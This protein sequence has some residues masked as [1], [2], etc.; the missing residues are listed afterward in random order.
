[1]NKFFIDNR[2]NFLFF[3]VSLIFLFAIIG[4][5]NIFF[6][7]TE[8]LYLGE[9]AMHQL[10]WHFFKNDIWRFPLGSNPN[11]GD[12]LGSSIVFSDSIPILALFFKLFKFFIPNNFQYFSFWY[13]I[14][15]YFQLFFAYKILQKF[16]NS[17]P[18]SFVGAIFFVIAPI[19]IYRIHLHS[20]LAGQWLLLFT[21]YLGLVH[22]VNKS[23]FLWSILLI[24]SS[25]IHFY[26]TA[27]ILVAYTILR[28]LNFYFDKEKFLQ[29]VKDF[30]IIILS[31]LLVL[32]L[33]GYFQIRM[34]DSLGVGFG[35]YKLNLLSIFDSTNSV[36]NISWSWILPDIKL[37]RGEEL[38]GFNYLGL[39]QILMLL[40]G[41]II[42]FGRNSSSINLFIRE[43]R[44]F[45]IFLFI[46][47]VFTCWAISSNISLG[48]H[49]YSIPLNKYI[50]GLLSIIKSSGRAFWLVNY[51]LLLL[52]IIIIF[53]YFDKKKSFL[54]ILIFLFI[55]IFD[56]SA[57]LKNYFKPFMPLY[58]NPMLAMDDRD[59]LKDEIWEDLFSNNKVIKTTYPVSWS[60]LFVKFA[61]LIE[62]YNMEKTNLVIFARSNRQANAQARYNL[63]NNLRSKQIKTNTVYIIHDL[64]HLRNLKSIFKDENVS[65]FYRDNMWSMALNHNDLINENDKENFN[66]IKPKLIEFNKVE[67]LI[68]ENKDNYYGFGWSHNLGKPGIWSEGKVS[69]LLFSVEESN[70]DLNLELS[71]EPH[72][73]NKYNYLDFDVYVNNFL[74]QNVKLDLT[75]SNKKNQKIKIFIKSADITENQIK[76]DLDF[77]NPVSPMEVF[78]SPDSRKLGILLKNI[79]ISTI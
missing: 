12:D 3:I 36:K 78:A 18:Y 54:I 73:T 29:V 27:M 47:F 63:Y 77:K 19:F 35:Y 5:K 13:L 26:F 42:C 43:N 46:A 11:Y 48:S 69:T 67:N 23:T 39:G 68:F 50:F 41:I 75:G 45:K 1:M 66:K 21:L 6:G 55:Q 44:Q 49:T 32:Y 65:F 58:Q 14:C 56:L 16:T 20:A 76:I 24:I 52:S 51:F 74:K 79:K 72:I 30:L 9:P 17:I 70:K 22:K 25:L 60:G 37:S 31:L 10:G 53:K 2:V 8:W 62:K 7:N 64:G 34:A 57:G 4:P 15:F 28:M 71:I 61:P 40:F 33:V 59:I 38:E